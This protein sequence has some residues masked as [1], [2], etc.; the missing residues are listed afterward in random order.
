MIWVKTWT[1]LSFR[2]LKPYYAESKLSC[3][4]VEY[5]QHLWYGKGCRGNAIILQDANHA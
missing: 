2:I 1:V 3:T 5:T 4:V